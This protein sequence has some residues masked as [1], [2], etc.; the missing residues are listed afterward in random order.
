MAAIKGQVKEALHLGWDAQAG[1]SCPYLWS[2]PCWEAWTI[3]RYMNA[4]GRQITGLQKRR[5]SVY[6]TP[7]GARIRVNYTAQGHY[8]ERES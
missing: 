3:G 8:V 1:E 4:T 6:E 2:S 7:S 5:G